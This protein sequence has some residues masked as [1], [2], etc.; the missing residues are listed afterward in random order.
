MRKCIEEQLRI[1]E[2][3][4][5]DIQLDMRSRD[6][7]PKILYGLIEIYKNEEMREKIFA[8]L[9]EVIPSH[10]SQITGRPGISFWQI[11]VLGNIRLT[12]NIDY[13]KLQEL[14]NQHQSIRQ[15]LGH[16]IFDDKQYPLQTLKDNL[17]LFTPDILDR[18]NKVVVEFGRQVAGADKDEDIHAKCDSFPVPTNVHFPTDISLLFDALRKI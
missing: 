5:E 14:A 4:I 8:I 15:M 3:D 9:K 2:V 13:D 17:M 1:G 10:I 12:C 6:E 16:S 18:I 11:F 7:I